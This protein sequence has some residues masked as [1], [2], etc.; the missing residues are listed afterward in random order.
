MTTAIG[1]ETS[2]GELAKALALGVVLLAIALS[3]NIASQ[4]VRSKFERN[5]IN[6]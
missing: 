6:D 2:R 5:I 3:V 1:L 4:M